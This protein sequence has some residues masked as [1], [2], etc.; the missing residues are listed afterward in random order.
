MHQKSKRK[1][2]IEIIHKLPAFTNYKQIKEE[3]KKYLIFACLIKIL[4]SPNVN[5]WRNLLVLSDEN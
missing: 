3:G 1:A 2:Q 4:L 5:H